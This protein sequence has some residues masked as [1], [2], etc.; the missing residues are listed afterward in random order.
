M[1]KSGVGA[2]REAQVVW[3]GGRAPPGKDTVQRFWDLEEGGLGEG[4]VLAAGAAQPRR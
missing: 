2:L 1:G 4:R 3:L